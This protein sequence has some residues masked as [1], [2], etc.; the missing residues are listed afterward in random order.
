M[1]DISAYSAYWEQARNLYAPFETTVTM[2]SG[3]A[4]VYTNEIPGMPQ[5][6]HKGY[7]TTLNF[8]IPRTAQLIIP[9]EIMTEYFWQF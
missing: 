7:L 8:G 1:K 9:N 5:P 6:S 3:N 4:D 2:R